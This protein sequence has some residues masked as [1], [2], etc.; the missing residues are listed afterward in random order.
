[1]NQP[2]REEFDRLE[3]NQKRL[4]EEVRQL[5]EQQTEP[6]KVTRIEL[7][8]KDV[9]LTLEKHLAILKEISDRQDRLDDLGIKTFNEVRRVNAAM[10]KRF[11]AIADVQKAILE[12]L[13][14]KGE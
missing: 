10:E 7:E 3:A 14:E 11:D 13:P 5:R 6:V 1:M 2:T 4:E 9:Q 12:R 8:Q